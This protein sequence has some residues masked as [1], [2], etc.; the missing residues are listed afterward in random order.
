MIESDGLTAVLLQLQGLTQQ[1]AELDHR[2]ASDVRQIQDRIAGLATLVSSIKD[3]AADQADTLTAIKAIHERIDEL[4]AQ[5]AGE[6]DDEAAEV[7]Q[8]R[9]SRRWWKLE[10]A[11]REAS[12]ASLRA[13]V[14][15]IYLPGYGYL[16]ASLGDCWDQHPLCLYALDWLSELWSVLYLQPQRT[17]PVLAGQAE[18][19]TRLLAAVAEQLAHETRHCHH[20]VPRSRVPIRMGARP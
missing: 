15:Q 17:R 19:Q 4:A 9:P 20:A 13:W 12:I 10:G 2:E 7:Y 11:E 18:W 3:T 8:P 5:I 6:P 14:D 1:L 16:A